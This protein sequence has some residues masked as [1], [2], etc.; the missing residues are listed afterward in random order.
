MATISLC[1]RETQQNA[2]GIYTIK[3]AIGAK[4][5]TTYI[6]TRFKIDSLKQWK[7]GK[8]V[9]RSDAD[10]LNRKLRHVLTE[11][12]NMLD[13][14]CDSSMSAVEIRKFIESRIKKSNSLKAYAKQYIARLKKRG[15]RFLR[16][17][18]G[19]YLEICP[20]ESWREHNPARSRRG[21]AGEV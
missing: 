20:G 17:E 1:V 15:T 18:Y 6:A 9:K 16:T 14:V 21:T 5:R 4:S 13:E 11:Y 8:I 7:D 2:D 10:V 12:K 19:L 3:I